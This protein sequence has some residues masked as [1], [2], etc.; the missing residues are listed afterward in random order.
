MGMGKWVGV[1]VLEGGG[2]GWG[3]GRDEMGAGV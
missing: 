3:F 2:K 1:G